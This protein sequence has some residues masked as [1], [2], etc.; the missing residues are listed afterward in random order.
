MNISEILR[1]NRPELSDLSIKTYSSILF[2]L[3]T[4][5]YG[6]SPL[7]LTKF[8]DN[9]KIIP[10]LAVHKNP[11]VRKT[12]LSALFVI[13]KNPV[14]QKNML[15]DIKTYN[16]EINEQTLTESQKDSWLTENELEEA[17][18]TSRLHAINAY[19]T[20]NTLFKLNNGKDI[21]GCFKKPLQ[22]I[23]DYIILALTS[24]KYILP[25]RS[26]DYCYFKISNIDEYDNYIKG[27]TLYFKRF[28]GSDSKGLQKIKIPL[29]LKTILTRWIKIN[30][31]D[32]LLFDTD[33]NPMTN[34]KLT[35]RLNK[36][37]GK[38]SSVNA[39]RHTYLT[40]KH[41]DVLENLDILK[42]DMQM[43]GSSILQAKTYIKKIS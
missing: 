25:R 41:K 31:T 13:T 7:T 28:K 42:N 12:I 27:N 1:K 21:G 22:T 30:P 14:Y 40:N 20:F 35:Q 15:E 2:N 37:F 32:N 10:Y 43:M 9:N 38:K 8:D 4:S 6:D 11:N 39:I 34:V 33:Y 18:E 23:Q 24:G 19:K 36:I 26:A 17:L 29:A 5:I 16:K 3:F